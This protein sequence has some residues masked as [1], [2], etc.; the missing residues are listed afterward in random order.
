L[1][2]LSNKPILLDND[3]EAVARHLNKRGYNN[4]AGSE[5]THAVLD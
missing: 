5:D 4:Q 1:N 3:S 2:R